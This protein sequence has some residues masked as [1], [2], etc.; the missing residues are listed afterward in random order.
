MDTSKYVAEYKQLEEE[1]SSGNLSSQ[2]LAQ[3]PKKP[4]AMR[5]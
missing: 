5:F 3:K 2:E 1:L 4:N